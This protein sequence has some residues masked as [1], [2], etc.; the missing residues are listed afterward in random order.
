MLDFLSAIADAISAVFSLLL[1]AISAIISFFGL[2]F[3]FGAYLLLVL[4]HI[5]PP[6]VAFIGMG[7]SLSILL[8]IV[9]RN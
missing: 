5:P 8:L 2:V 9:G 6:L 1:N 7:I 3:E 4:G